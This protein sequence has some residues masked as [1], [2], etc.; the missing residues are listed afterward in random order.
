V[1]ALDSSSTKHGVTV[2]SLP[3]EEEAVPRTAF[4]VRA[5]AAYRAWLDQVL[6]DR[7]AMRAQLQVANGGP[8]DPDPVCT[9]QAATAGA[10][11]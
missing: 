1:L 3:A 10:W 7:C 2:Y 4:T 11:R 9:P 8:A 5:W 6:A